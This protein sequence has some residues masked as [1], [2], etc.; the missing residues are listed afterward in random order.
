MVYTLVREGKM[1]RKEF[2]KYLSSIH[3]E[4]YN[5]A[6]NE[7]YNEGIVTGMLKSTKKSTRKDMMMNFLGNK[8]I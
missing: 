1:T 6:Y 4:K 7:G 2:E 5:A 3:D 8:K